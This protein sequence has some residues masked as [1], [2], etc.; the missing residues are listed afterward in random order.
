MSDSEDVKDSAVQKIRNW[1]ESSFPPTLLATLVTAQHF[2][3]FQTLPMLFPPVLLLS[4]Y[5]NINGFKT[6]AAG[7][8]AAWSGLYLLL[9]MRRKQS[10]RN[11]FGV[12]G[13]TRGATL[14]LCV[15]NMVGG[16]LAYTFGKREDQEE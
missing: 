12:R 5:L 15:A 8:S 13:V 10:I 6:D 14:G 7:I 1:G 16:G 2:K 4:S 11:K 3:P 9:A